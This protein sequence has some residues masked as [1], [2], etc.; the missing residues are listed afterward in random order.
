M[1]KRLSKIS[2]ELLCSGIKKEQASGMENCKYTA[3]YRKVECKMLIQN[4][5]Y[6]NVD[7]ESEKVVLYK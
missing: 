3:V 4:R 6:F 1:K 7:F 2:Q 5:C